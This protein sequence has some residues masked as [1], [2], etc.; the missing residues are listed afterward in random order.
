MDGEINKEFLFNYFAGRATAL[1]KQKIDV[2]SHEPENREQFYKW[3]H[4]WESLNL[5]YS[6]DLQ[7]GMDVHWQRM[8]LFEMTSGDQRDSFSPV[9]T[10]HGSSRFPLFYRMASVAAAVVALFVFA[11]YQKD[12]LFFTTYQT[13]FGETTSVGLPDGSK[14]VLNANSKLLVPRFGFGNRTR[15]VILEGEADFDVQQT[16]DAKK[17]IV[18][19]AKGVEVVVL[20]TVFNVY[21]R[22]RATKV[23]LNEGSVQLNYKEG[24]ENKQLLMSPGDLVTL[25]D[26]GQ[27]NIKKTEDPAKFSAWKSREIVFSE[28]PLSEIGKI[29]EENYGI[30]I[31]IPDANLANLT[32]SGSFPAG[33]GQELLNL[34]ME[35][36]GL[37]LMYTR[38]GTAIL[39][40]E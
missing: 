9:A 11:F 3:L 36:S 1:Q 17:F 40:A 15:E 23:V 20:G 25:D 24:E 35:G 31:L 38:E 6:S 21:A 37:K 28:T 32:V 2:W 12:Y 14:I 18:R 8:Q 7:T 16:V 13:G 19:T 27:T 26:N 33:D 5:Q 10:D 30:K 39:S 22:P 34:L 4:E 29:F